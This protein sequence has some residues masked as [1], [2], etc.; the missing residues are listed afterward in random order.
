M[1]VP[2]FQVMFKLNP[3]KSIHLDQSQ[4]YMRITI[5][6]S[7]S[8]QCYL[9]LIYFVNIFIS[10]RQLFLYRTILTRPLIVGWT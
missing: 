3:T 1:T 9:N 10:F 6:L 8:F 7:I 5:T 4:A 2:L